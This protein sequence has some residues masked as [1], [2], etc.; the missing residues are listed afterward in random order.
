MRAWSRRRCL[1]VAMVLCLA[2]SGAAGAGVVGAD[3]LGDGLRSLQVV[4]IDAG[5]KL[6]HYLPTRLELSGPGG[7][8]GAPALVRLQLGEDTMLQGFLRLVADLADERQLAIRAEALLGSDTRIDVDRT[9]E[10]DLQISSDGRPVFE[11]ARTMG[12]LGHI[13]VHLTVPGKPAAQLECVLRLFPVR[14]SVRRAVMVA[15]TSVQVG[16]ET[17]DGG[18]P[19]VHRERTDASAAVRVTIEED[20]DAG[21]IVIRQAL[22]VPPAD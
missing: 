1:Q 16:S 12:N 14:P 7:P 20:A 4:R 11:L 8:G 17:I 5:K 15:E 9:A 19:L 18:A 6:V 10:F 13:P 3:E 2:W 22:P 21:A